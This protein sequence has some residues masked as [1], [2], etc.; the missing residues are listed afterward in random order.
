MNI[1][2]VTLYLKQTDMN[3]PPLNHFQE[4]MSESESSVNYK[5]TVSLA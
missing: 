4:R 1:F 2:T 3:S 5:P